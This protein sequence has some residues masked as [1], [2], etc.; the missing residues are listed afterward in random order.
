MKTRIRS[1]R[2]LWRSAWAPRSRPTG[3]CARLLRPRSPAA[4]A[5]LERL[6]RR[7]EHWRRLERQ[8][9]PNR[10]PPIGIATTPSAPAASP[11]EPGTP[12]LFFLPNNNQSEQWRRHRRPAA[13][14]QLRVRP[15]DRGWRRKRLPGLELSGQGPSNYAFYPSPYLQPNGTFNGQLILVAAINGGNL[16]LDY[17]GTVRGRAG[18]LSTPTLLVY[19]TAGF[20]YGGVSAWSQTNIRSGWTAGGGLEW[21]FAPN[22]SAKVEYSMPICRAAA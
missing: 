11:I 21:M 9:R 14:L 4:P 3:R 16:V 19:G 6:L 18:R 15:V 20:A 13:R 22:W 7:S 10:S 5:D 8:Q 2:W 17:I 12:N 1:R